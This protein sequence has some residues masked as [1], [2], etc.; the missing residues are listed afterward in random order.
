MIIHS[1]KIDKSYFREGEVIGEE[2]GSTKNKKAQK[3][4]G[5]IKESSNEGQHWRNVFYV[6]IS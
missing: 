4:K 3:E 2:E 1:W 6:Q 5:N